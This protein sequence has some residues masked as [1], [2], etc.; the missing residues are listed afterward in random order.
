M[1]LPDRNNFPGKGP[2]S[3]NHNE[4]GYHSFAE[5][6]LDPQSLEARKN[7]L[8]DKRNEATPTS[9]QRWQKYKQGHQ[10]EDTKPPQ[11][12][13]AENGLPGAGEG[14]VKG[15]L[16][17]LKNEEL[18][19]P[20]EAMRPA[21][22]TSGIISNARDNLNRQMAPKQPVA[23]V[24]VV[25]QDKKTESELQWDR[26]QRRLKRQLKIKD[27]DFT[28]LKDEDDEDVFCPPKLFFDASDG[29]PPPPGGLP[30]PPPPPVGGCPPPPPPLGLPPPPPPPGG[31]PP[32]P[33]GGRL[34]P[35]SSQGSTTLP[36]PPGASLK[37]NK[38]TVRLHWRAL[39]GDSPHPSTK[40]EI[41]WRQLVPITIDTDKLE[42]LF[43][44]KTSELKAKASF[45]FSSLCLLCSMSLFLH[46]KQSLIYLI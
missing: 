11:S 37:K 21:G 29:P 23:P 4:S 19:V 24:P 26:I 14:Q 5:A 43:E 41:I 34:P 6:Q 31:L 10:V 18:I 27:M 39:P 16:N 42:H 25:E 44:T 36:P 8:N 30:P 2:P 40:G 38:K 28:D 35:T 1:P 46:Y 45:D 12:A 33:P 20:K 22:D 7:A 32:P 13:R 17:K 9:N 15:M 3:A